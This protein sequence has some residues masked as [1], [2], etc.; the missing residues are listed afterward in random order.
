MIVMETEIGLRRRDIENRHDDPDKAG[1]VGEPAHLDLRER[2]VDLPEKQVAKHQHRHVTEGEPGE[3]PEILPVAGIRHELA[4]PLQHAPF[5]VR[6][7]IAVRTTIQRSIHGDQ[8]R[9]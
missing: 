7:A 5:I 9:T 6:T 3:L 1:D 4:E 2:Q 8:L